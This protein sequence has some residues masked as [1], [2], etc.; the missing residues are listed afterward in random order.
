M[1]V[2]E[3]HASEDVLRVERAAVVGSGHMGRGIALALLAAECNVV[4][5]DTTPDR[6][7][8]AVLWILAELR[9]R[10]EK[11]PATAHDA[12]RWQERL[13][14][15]VAISDVANVDLVVEAIVENLDAKRKLFSE[16]DQI[17]RPEALFATNTS[18]L[19][20]NVIA[21]VTTRRSHVLGMHFFSPAHVQ[22]L[23]EVID[24]RETSSSTLNQVLNLVARMGKT[25]V[26]AQVGVGFIGNRIFDSYLLA[27]LDCALAGASPHVIDHALE[28]FGFAMGPFRVMDLV[29]LD[30]LWAV[31]QQAGNADEP[32]WTLLGDVVALGDLGNKTGAG[33]FAHG[34]DRAFTERA[35]IVA[36]LGKTTQSRQ[37]HK[38][39]P[40]E[41]VT[42][43]LTALA[44]EGQRVV[45]EGI[46][47]NT[48]DVDT[49]FV[50]GYGFPADK[51][52]P[53]AYARSTGL[54]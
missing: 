26:V 27:A 47:A 19:D 25:A 39:T 29:G 44:M 9:R 4:L 15:A 42:R 45:V 48:D 20:V 17:V 14:A 34:P 21:E 54:I 37:G 13:T 33:W 11:N 40:E 24:A 43:C 36:L 51:G 3:P 18:T 35:E 2:S 52:G 53:M 23:V 50:L 30:I 41:I 38:L 1:T 22:K 31:R 5:F 49:V 28:D 7:A 32:G 12:A 8:E 46:A 16:L 10:A 6:A